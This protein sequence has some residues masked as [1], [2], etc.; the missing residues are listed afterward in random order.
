MDSSDITLKKQLQLSLPMGFEQLVN[1]LMTVI[2]TF[3]V[4]LLGATAIAEVGAMGT[5]IS[6]LLILPNT[7]FIS[8]NVIIANYIGANNKNAIKSTLGNSIILG[9]LASIGLGVI[10][11]LISP[12]FPK[13]FNVPNACLTYLYIRLLGFLFLT[14]GTILSGYER[15]K[16]NAKFMLYLKITSLIFNLILDIVVVKLGYGINGVAI[17]TILIDVFVMLLLLCRNI[18]DISL[19]FK[20]KVVKNIC[21]YIKWNTFERLI[22]KIDILIMNLIVA[23]IGTLEYSVHVLLSQMVDIYKEF[24]S[25]IQ[26]GITI[27]V[28]KIQGSGKYELYKKLKET[29]YKLQ[30]Y[31]FIFTPLLIIVIAF[32]ISKLYFKDG[33]QIKIFYEIMPIIIINVILN[34]ISI[35]Y[36]AYLRGVKDFKFLAN[37]NLISS[38]LKIVVAFI[39]SYYFGVI[40]VW[41]SYFIYSFSQYYMSRK[42]YNRIK[43]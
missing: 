20:Y 24:I 26:N 12:N 41:L 13:L 16:G 5:I 15:T 36:Y 37:R 43:L 31:F 30:K 33:T 11:F 8:N 1:I 34:V 7:I 23:N 22:T 19:K 10:T 35:Y 18:K 28:G 9:L 4:G 17:I 14:I 39:F 25:G 29:S 21:Y 3:V 27:N 38:I 42:R 32:I 6:V 40:G 2:D